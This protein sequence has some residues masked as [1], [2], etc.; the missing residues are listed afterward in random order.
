LLAAF[1]TCRRSPPSGPRA[2]V[3]FLDRSDG[4]RLNYE[5]HGDRGSPALVLL[6]GMGGGIPGWRR[7]IPHLAAELFVVAYDHRGNGYSEAPDGPATMRTF[8]DD[9]LALLEEL[10]LERSHLY[11]QSFGGMVAQEFA[12]WHPERVRS[13]VLAC[14]HA[15][16][17]HLVPS[18]GRA[19]KDQPWLQLYSPS[20]A[21][22]H[23]EHVADDLRVGRAQP[24]HPQGQRRQ[25][26]AVQE[27]D[28]YDQLPDL[29]VPTLVLHGAEDQ[30]IDVENARVLAERIPGAELVVIEGA[31][32]VYH[33][34][35]ADLADEVVLD[36]LRRLGGD[37]RGGA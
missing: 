27:W 22:A 25:R 34:E 6:E 35:Q 8:A 14:T 32:H 36:F 7:N 23:P 16:H 20:F 2:G 24:Q 13:L 10:H 17:R 3:A 5:T 9:L 21:K 15:G 28:A 19:P 29:R 1:A 11:G 18:T 37:V 26:E 31:G 33:S 4:A 12:L 30:L